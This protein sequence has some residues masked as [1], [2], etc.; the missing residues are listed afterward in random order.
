MGYHVAEGVK[1]LVA[2]LQLDHLTLNGLVELG[3]GQRDGNLIGK[4]G[5]TLRIA[6]RIKARLCAGETDKAEHLPILTDGNGDRRTLPAQLFDLHPVGVGGDVV[7][8]HRFLALPH[9]LDMGEIPNG[10]FERQ[11]QVRQAPFIKTTLTHTAHL[12]ALDHEDDGF[13][14]SHHLL[15]VDEDEVQHFFQVERA[16]EGGA[17]SAQRLGQGALFVLGDLGPVPVEGDLDCGMQVAVVK[18]LDQVAERLGHLGPLDR[19]LVGVS[20]NINDRGA[21]SGPDLRGSL[22]PI[23]LANQ[24]DVHQNQVRSRFCRLLDRF[25]A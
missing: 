6:L 17:G 11:H 23:H 19:L 3:V 9:L 22:D 14:V 5:Q 1:L 20:R 7:D 4:R 25:L 24:S 8:Q 16:V 10:P 15:Q 2:M 13:A 18:G 12:V 21:P